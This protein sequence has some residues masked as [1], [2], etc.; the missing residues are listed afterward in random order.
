M[1]N[2]GTAPLHLLLIDDD[3][4]FRYTVGALLRRLGHR[5]EEAESGA[6]A[7][8]L[9]GKMPVD[10]VL[11]DLRMPGMTGWEVARLTKTLHPSVPVVIV[12]GC[13]ASLA[14]DQPER[15]YVDAI[16]EKPCGAVQL[17]A[18][19]GALT[20]ARIAAA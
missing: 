18:V 14:A 4:V 16:L 17:Q 12:T 9:L 15:Q 20:A 19:L 3:P 7:L 13:A 11:T 5:V 6:A 2:L 10:L 1:I 8:A